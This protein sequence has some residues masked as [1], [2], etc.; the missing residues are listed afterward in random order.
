VEHDKS[1]VPDEIAIEWLV[2]NTVA[3]CLASYVVRIMDELQA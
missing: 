2:A 3:D 1:A